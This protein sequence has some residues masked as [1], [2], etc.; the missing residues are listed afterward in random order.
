VQPTQLLA[1]GIA[2]TAG[3]R[4]AR[5]FALLATVLTAH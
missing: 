1:R 2:K 4:F 3:N 5:M